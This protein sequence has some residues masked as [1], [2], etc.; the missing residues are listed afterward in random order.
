MAGG[1]CQAY[2]SSTREKSGIS[3]SRLQNNSIEI[4]SKLIDGHEEEPRKGMPSLDAVENWTATT[5]RIYYTCSASKAA[6]INFYDFGTRTA[7][8]LCSLPRSPTSGGGLAVSPD[9]RWLLYTRTDD[10]QSDILLVNH[11]QSLLPL[12]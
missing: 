7:Q 8:H 6:T 1:C 2:S 9:G 4:W 3:S 12:C 11:F 10:A 5:R